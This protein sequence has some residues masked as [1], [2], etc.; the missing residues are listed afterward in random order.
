RIHDRTAV[1]RVRTTRQGVLLE[2]QDGRSIR[3][4]RIVT[5]SGYPATR[6]LSRR[7]GT[8]QST[9][10][11]VTEPLPH[12]AGWPH[13]CLFWATARPYLYIRSTDDGRLLAGG[14]D[15]PG[16]ERHRQPHR[17]RKKI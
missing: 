9:W 13:R 8:L 14:E 4:N 2:T 17:F 12:F 15:E 5:A 6:Q 11:F 10:A 1:T 3:A 7:T 16:P